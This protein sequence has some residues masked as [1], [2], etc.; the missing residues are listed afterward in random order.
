MNSPHSARRLAL[1]TCIAAGATLAAAPP[2]PAQRES[3][4]RHVFASVVDK[5]NAPVPD[6]GV[7]DFTVAED[8][9]TREIIKVAPA[10][11]PMQIALLVDNS[12]AAEP[13][14]PDLRK[15]CAGFVQKV[16]E[17][18]PT[19]E[20][21][22]MTFGE[23]PVTETQ[24]T[25][26]SIPLL[27]GCGSLIWRS[28]SGAYMIQAVMEAS[29]ALKKHGATRPLVV[30]FASE[31]GP[32]FSDFRHERVIEGLK[33]AG[34]TLWTMA[35]QP[36]ASRTSVEFA[37]RPEGR[38]RM[39][40]LSGVSVESGGENKLILAQQSIPDVF[41][42]VATMLTSEYD[43]T[44]GRPVMLIP[45]QKLAVTVKR[46]GVRLWAPRWAEQ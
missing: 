39:E 10:T 8:G 29:K 18:S 28:G 13:L 15:A 45:P 44:Y 41:L 25:T 27:R 30:V 14:M 33:A 43:V 3:R 20:I 46:P 31:E 38:E 16:L 2:H 9:I 4:E 19:S 6:L 37:T 35:Y 22:L 11:A 5:N 23:R 42:N 21:S 34:A 26:S 17:T 7:A 36:P 24:F 40:V 32:E 1:V 12:A